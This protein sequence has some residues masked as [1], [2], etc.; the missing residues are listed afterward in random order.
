MLSQ[1]ARCIGCEDTNVMIANGIGFLSQTYEATA[2]LIGNTILALSA[3][4]ISCQQVLA[5]FELLPHIIKEVLRYDPAIQNTRRFVAH[6]GMVAGQRMYEGETILVVLAA[7]NRDSTVNPDP[8]R[9]EIHRANRSIFTFGL[10]GHACPGKML[11]ATIARVGIEQLLTSGLDPESLNETVLYRP[12]VNA[13]IPV[14]G[15]REISA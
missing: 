13:R 8:D 3:H 9:F 12:S 4:R 11:A 10:G 1:E 5:D 6:G 2:G 15:T 7:A 14:W